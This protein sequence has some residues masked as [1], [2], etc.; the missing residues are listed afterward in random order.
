MFLVG[1]YSPKENNDV[2][3]TSLSIYYKMKET[4]NF[5]IAFISFKIIEHK[6]NDSIFDHFSSLSFQEQI[7]KIEKLKKKFDMI[8]FDTSNSLSMNILQYI[9]IVDRLFIVGDG[10]VNFAQQL[11]RF[12]YWNHFFDQNNKNL[13]FT[14]LE[15]NLYVLREQKG[16]K[17]G[18]LQ[19]ENDVK[20]I[21]D[22]IHEDFTLSFLNEELRKKHLEILDE[23]KNMGE[24]D[25]IFGVYHLGLPF[26][27]SIL[28]DKFIS[29]RIA[30][31]QERNEAI[32]DLFLFIFEDTYENCYSRFQTELQVS[33][34]VFHPKQS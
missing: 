7:D 3:N 8:I 26:P 6:K 34:I 29:L 12:T 20:K 5:S 17:V 16:Q 2:T 31:G 18:F 15:D 22:M 33:Q 11:Q 28:F 21:C 13:P 1:F 14:P 30:L 10:N 23:I 4:T 19:K 9:S 32:D 25:L 24:D 27:K